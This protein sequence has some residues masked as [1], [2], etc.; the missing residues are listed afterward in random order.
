V[1]S[2]FTEPGGEF[3]LGP[4]ED[5]A[6]DVLIFPHESEGVAGW[7]RFEWTVRPGGEAIDF[8]VPTCLRILLRD[9]DGNAVT[10]QDVRTEISYPGRGEPWIEHFNNRSRRFTELRMSSTPK[11][12]YTVTV[13]VAGY[14][15]A[16]GTVTTD[17]EGRADLEMR[18]IPAKK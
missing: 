9:G 18:L 4:F 14:E 15:P 7:R 16:K 6:H 1:T 11:V 8:V 10:S 17:A 12:T 2:G 13:R 5:S 3:S